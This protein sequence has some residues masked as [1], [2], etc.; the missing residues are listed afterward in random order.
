MFI[1]MFMMFTASGK[2]EVRLTVYE[3][4]SEDSDPFEEG[5]NEV[6][7]EL[8]KIGELVVNDQYLMLFFQGV[9]EEDIEEKGLTHPLVGRPVYLEIQVGD[10]KKPKLIQLNLGYEGGFYIIN[11]NS[12][13]GRFTSY[14][15][16]NNGFYARM[17]QKYL[18][19]QIKGLVK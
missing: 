13:S 17:M 6:N 18:V 9:F 14:H 3:E 5:N 11:R 1:L 10:V 7:F 4:S 2:D 16:S 8:K 19:S 15:P 12:K